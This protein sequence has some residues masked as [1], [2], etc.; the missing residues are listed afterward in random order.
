MHPGTDR[1]QW[2]IESGGPPVP[3]GPMAIAHRVPTVA[4][5]SPRVSPGPALRRRLLARRSLAGSVALV[6]LGLLAAVAPSI[7][8][9]F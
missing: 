1:Y 2:V 7:P 9:A 4:L 6:L 5:T 8:D 3:T